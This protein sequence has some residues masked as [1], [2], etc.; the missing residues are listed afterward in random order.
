MGNTSKERTLPLAGKAGEQWRV[1]LSGEKQ[2]DVGSAAGPGRMIR[3][4]P[5]LRDGSKRD[6][7]TP[8]V[9]YQHPSSGR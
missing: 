4:D 3:L 2:L 9:A 7:H 5:T 1:E 8:K 6:L